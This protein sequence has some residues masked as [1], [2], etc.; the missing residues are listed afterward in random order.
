MSHIC[1]SPPP[2]LCT[3][4][5]LLLFWNA[6]G[7]RPKICDITIGR[8]NCFSKEKISLLFMDDTFSFFFLLASARELQRLIYQHLLSMRRSMNRAVL[9]EWPLSDHCITCSSCVN[10]NVRGR[11]LKFP[12]WHTKA[13]SNGKCCEGYIVP[14]MVRLMYQLKSVLK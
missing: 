1:L 11:V 6:C 12:A 2:I 7:S 14:S 13:A 5:S 3:F 9:A 4:I 8:K 10:S